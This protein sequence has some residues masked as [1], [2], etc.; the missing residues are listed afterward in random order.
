MKSILI[1]YGSTG[2]NTQMVVE[3]VVG[4]LKEAGVSADCQRAEQSNIE[5]INKADVVVLASPTYGHGILERYMEAFCEKLKHVDFNKKQMSVI[6]VGEAKYEL[7]YHLE[8]AR[9]LEDLIQDCGG[10]MILPPLKISG[11]PVRHLTGF[12][13]KWS[14]QM[15]EKL[16]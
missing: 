10:E 4:H 11:S 5:D 15:V 7:Q 14:A 6:G 13:P 8:S 16:I 9:I 1:I 2:G 3:A 12:I